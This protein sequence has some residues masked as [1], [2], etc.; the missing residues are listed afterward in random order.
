MR[1][2]KLANLLIFLLSDL[3]KILPN[4]YLCICKWV[5]H[6]NQKKQIY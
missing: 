5:K 6:A 4:L 2:I 3:K 1:I